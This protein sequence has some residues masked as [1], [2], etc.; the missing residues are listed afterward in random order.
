MTRLRF[1]AK[2]RLMIRLAVSYARLSPEF[3]ETEE[4][5]DRHAE[6]KWDRLEE[7]LDR[8]VRLRG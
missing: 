4:Q 7:K 2:E 5:S 3:N 8:W 1:S 6:A